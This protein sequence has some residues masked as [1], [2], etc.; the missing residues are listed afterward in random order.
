MKELHVLVA[1]HASSSW[2]LLWNDD[3]TITWI[4]PLSLSMATAVF[5]FFFSYLILKKFL[6]NYIRVRFSP[7]QK[8]PGPNHYSFLMGAFLDIQREP[9]MAPHKRWCREFGYD[10]PFLRYPSLFF[11]QSL[12]ILDKDLVQLILTA[13]PGSSSSSSSSNSS[14]TTKKKKPRFGKVEAHFLQSRIGD[15]LVTLEGDDWK[16]HRRILQPS[17]QTNFLK[18][19]LDETVPPVAD[20]LIAAWKEGIAAGSPREIDAASHLS[21][22]TLDVVGKVLFSHDFHGLQIIQK[23]AAKR[24]EVDHETKTSPDESNCIHVSAHGH[25]QTESTLCCFDRFWTGIFGQIYQSIHSQDTSNVESC[26]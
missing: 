3:G 1:K 23:W 7:L 20:A 8:I 18:E 13:P 6:F 22:V 10:Q 26:R 5:F 2:S 12:L 14:T 24:I 25:P 16:R 15:G 4:A 9:F 11:T 17:F 21:T 19:S